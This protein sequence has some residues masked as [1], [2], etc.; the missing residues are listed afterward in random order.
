MFIKFDILM[1]DDNRA[2]C[3]ASCS[4]G[5]THWPGLIVVSVLF[6]FVF[7]EH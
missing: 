2:P 3:L 5:S 7:G 4:F 6:C 1:M